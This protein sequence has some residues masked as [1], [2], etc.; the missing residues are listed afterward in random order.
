MNQLDEF[1]Q[2][3]NRIKNREQ[4][5]LAQ[6]YTE[7][8]ANRRSAS[9]KIGAALTYPLSLILAAALGILAVIAVRLAFFHLAGAT[10]AEQIT[11]K[12][13][14]LTVGLGFAGAFVAAQMLGLSARLQTLLLISGVAMAITGF[15][16]LFH[17]AP[18]AMAAAF[19]P[20]YASTITAMA[21]PNTAQLAGEVYAIAVPDF[22]LMTAI[23][24]WTAPPTVMAEA[25]PEKDIKPKLLI[26]DSKN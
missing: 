18:T 20:E 12:E 14:A 25:E 21:G 19:S 17:W 24:A 15:H 10:P 22:G 11:A 8:K 26:L 5:G 7:E 9:S 16:N 23:A 3:L 6:G 1:Q 2:R 4:L 13:I